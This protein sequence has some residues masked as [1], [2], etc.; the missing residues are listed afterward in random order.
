MEKVVEA[1]GHF[2][3]ASRNLELSHD[4]VNF[5]S[6]DGL[7]LTVSKEVSEACNL[8]SECLEL[9][10]RYQLIMVNEHKVRIARGS[11]QASKK[12][13]RRRRFFFFLSS[14]FFKQGQDWS[15]RI[16]MD[17]EVSWGKLADL[18]TPILYNDDGVMFVSGSEG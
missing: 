16:E 4:T 9:R 10:K 2:K 3:M 5:G 14:F 11:K 18:E 6:L 1:V 8:V 15:A 12:K 7:A 17:D 13:R